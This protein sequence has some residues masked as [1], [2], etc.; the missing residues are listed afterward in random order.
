MAGTLSGVADPLGALAAGAALG[1]GSGLSPG[2]LLALVLAQSLSHGPRE[3]IK[4]ALAPVITDVPILAVLIWAVSWVREHPGP[5]GVV[6]L[7]G[8]VVVTWFAVECL[9]A[10]AL[11]MPRA[12]VR[13]ASMRKGI[14]TNFANPHVYIFWGTVGAP[15]TVLAAEG[16]WLPPVL[17]LAGFYGCLVGG[18]VVLALL[19]GRFRGLLSG[20]G[21]LLTMRFLGVALFGFALF[22]V[23][24]GLRFLGIWP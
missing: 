20:R 17:F 18:K 7:A 19:A 24:D 13:P 5:M 23:R 2:P 14:L 11:E 21:Y 8:A 12:D 22:L 3:G 9:R 16:G 15:T 4:V 10:P 1:L 6:A